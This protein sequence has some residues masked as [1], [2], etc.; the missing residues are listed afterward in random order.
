[1]A[2]LVATLVTKGLLTNE[3]A[4][5]LAGAAQTILNENKDLPEDARELANATLRG[6]SRIWTTLVTR[7]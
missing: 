3:E 2:A 4:A 5:T 6:F 1:M 7:N